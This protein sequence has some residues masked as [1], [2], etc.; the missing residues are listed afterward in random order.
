MVGWLFAASGK[1]GAGVAS[2][3]KCKEGPHMAYVIDCVDGMQVRGETMNELRANTEKHIAEYHKGGNLDLDAVMA[4]AR[5][6]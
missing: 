6:E 5:E 3:T 4:T 2:D 1:R